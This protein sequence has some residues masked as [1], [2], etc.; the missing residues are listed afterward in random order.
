[1][2]KGFLMLKNLSQK[3]LSASWDENVVRSYYQYSPFALTHFQ[4]LVWEMLA[5]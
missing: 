5:V 3:S 1:M 2:A 4:A